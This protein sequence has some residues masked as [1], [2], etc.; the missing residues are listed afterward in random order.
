MEMVVVNSSRLVSLKAF[1][2]VSEIGNGA[3]GMRS[4]D[5]KE[6]GILFK[7]DQILGFVNRS[8][9][10]ITPLDKITTK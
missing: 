5:L 4:Y 6:V 3:I 8:A 7:H 2:I 9:A 10:N 1:Y